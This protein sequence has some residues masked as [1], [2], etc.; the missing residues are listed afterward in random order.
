ML[1][2]KGSNGLTIGQ[3][4]AQLGELDILQKM[5]E[6]A[7]EY[8]TT[9]EIQSKLLLPTDIF[10]GTIWHVVANRDQ[11]DI[12]QK[13][14][15]WAKENLMTEVIKNDMLLATDSD[16]ETAWHLAV[17]IGQPTLLTYL[18]TY[19]LHGAESFLRS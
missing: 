8:L 9:E 4:A 1:L 3:L 14:W 12:L 13:M 19:L 17:K 16:G 2:A 7:K 6:W 18:L 10:R 5:W 11:L 15:E